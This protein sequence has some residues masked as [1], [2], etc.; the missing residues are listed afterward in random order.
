MHAVSTDRY[1]AV[2]DRPP[3]YKTM[4]YIRPIEGKLL[5]YR[6]WSDL[7]GDAAISNAASALFNQFRR[8]GS[9]TSV[10][11]CVL[12]ETFNCFSLVLKYIEDGDQFCDG[13]QRIYPIG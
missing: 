11:K 3:V 9:S 2:P 8:H 4:R 7:N 1:F 12:L 5:L 13:Q 6:Q 10:S